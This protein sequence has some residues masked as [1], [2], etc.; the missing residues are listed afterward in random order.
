MNLEALADFNLVALHGGFGR[1]SRES[2]RSKATLSR[3][4][5]QL[6]QSLGVRL[7]ER[8]SQ[9]LRLTDEG[10]SLH[11]RTD[12]LLAE[13]AEAGE[14]V[15]SRA[16]LPRGRLR[17]SA[18]IVFAHVA[19]TRIAVRFA[20]D[21]PD[22]QLEIIAED[23]KVDPAE[24]GYDLVIRIDPP[25]DERLV[26]RRIMEDERLVVAAPEVP[27]PT[28]ARI[29]TASTDVP[30]ELDVAAVLLT[31]TLSDVVWR[32]RGGK[33]GERSLKPQP[34]LRFSSL[35][36]VRDAVLAG[37]GVALLPKL[38]VADDIATQRLTLWGI[39]NAPSVA[40]WALQSSRRLMSAK[41]RAFLGVLSETYPNKVFVPAR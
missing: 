30:S 4:V 32:I 19:L 37:A 20:A 10:R 35:L 1:A 34:A 39:H 2:G 24:D 33:A 14:T 5:T 7:I 41:V 6:E 22:V 23:R 28:E 11:E 38:L 15:A 25:A 8:G 16:P 17:V 36:M 13:I 31:A 3:R 18:P 21:Y 40:I 12:G 9:T 29:P 27:I 26:G